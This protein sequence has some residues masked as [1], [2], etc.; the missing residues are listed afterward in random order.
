[1]HNMH[2]GLGAGVG[3]STRG[4]GVDAHG[5]RYHALDPD[6]YY[7]AHSTFFVSTILIAEHFTGS[8]GETEK[9]RLFD[10]CVQW[11]RMYGMSMCP[12]RESWED[13]PRYRD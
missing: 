6:T 5:R 9:R 13:F 12:V 3:R 4:W 2:P 7:W 11:N 1:M 10:E 8:V